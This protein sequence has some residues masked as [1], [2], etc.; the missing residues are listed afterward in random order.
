MFDCSQVDKS[1]KSFQPRQKPGVASPMK[2]GCEPG[3]EI[4]TVIISHF[5]PCLNCF[6]VDG[7]LLLT[8]LMIF[9]ERNSSKFVGWVFNS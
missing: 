5:I 3:A 8:S 4:A 7:K 2:A 9:V 1:S 6:M